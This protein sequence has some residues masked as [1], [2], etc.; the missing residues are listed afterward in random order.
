MG[1][2]VRFLILDRD[3]ESSHTLRA[4]LLATS[5]VR[6]VAVADEPALLS[7]SVGRLHV[8]AVLINL[9]P[10]PEA[11][12][13]LLSELA[14]TYC[15]VAIFATSES[16]DGPLILKAMRA[17][18]KEFLP[19]PLDIDTLTEAVEKLAAR[20]D[21]TAPQGT[22]ITVM[23]ASGGVGATLLAT[24]LAVELA[25]LA[26][27]DVTI[28]DL[29]YRFGQV[30]T[31]LDI[32]PTFTLSDLCESPEQ[33]EPQVID[34]AL[35][36]HATGLRVLSRPSSLAEADTITAATCVG[37]L[38]TLVQLNEYVVVDGPSRTD[39]RAKAVLD[40]ADIN[41]LLVQL[42]VPCIRNA[43][44]LLNSLRSEG[45][46][47]DRT[48]LI[49][50]RTGRGAADL[51]I[52]DAARTLNLDAFAS[53]PDDWAAVSSAINL[54]EP[55]SIHSPKNKVRLAIR[56]I[57]ERLHG[58]DSGADDKEASKKGLIGRLLAMG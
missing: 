44:R 41:L 3:E 28:V 22:L 58:A 35:V 25:D 54:G 16:T 6:V 42:L 38:S 4:A 5:K 39:M 40:I 1:R 31:V 30:A 29:D 48:R 18:V 21:T 17:G 24:N 51:S 26:G 53:I 27:G 49:P 15:D 52:E 33:L 37:L 47:L 14:K 19:K 23:G 55:L 8:D 57:A 11:T 56:E 32:E 7:Q 10:E 50:N 43:T 34:R 12:L 36:K 13:P 45:D 9:D 20:Q 46:N 2:E